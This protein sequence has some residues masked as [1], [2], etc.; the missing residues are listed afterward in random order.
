MLKSIAPI[1]NAISGKL[2]STIS[3]SGD[4]TNEMTPNLKTISGDLFGQL[5]ESKVNASNSQLLTALGSNVKFIDVSK[6]NL[7]DVKA[8]LAF[9]D[10]KVAVKPFDIKYQDIKMQ[11]GG[12]H[13]FDQT[14]D[15]NVKF[16]VPAKYLGTEVNNLIAK[17]TPADAAKIENVPVNAMLGGNFGSPK[18]TTDMKMATTNLVTQLVKMQK[19]KL[20]GQGTSALTNLLGGN[21]AVSNA[22]TNTDTTKTTTPKTPTKDDVKE[23]VK[24]VIG[25]FLGGKKKKE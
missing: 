24:N 20:I 22:T 6:L 3:L 18:V 17:L 23:G 13:G 9:K 19:D 25:G 12:T 11:I 2:N 4:L 8:T 21:N 15:Y 10:G 16:D 1:A 7:D 14:M 5:L